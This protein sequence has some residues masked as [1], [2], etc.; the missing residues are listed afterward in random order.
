MSILP[1]SSLCEFSF[2]LK[3]AAAIL[4][5]AADSYL[6]PILEIRSVMTETEAIWFRRTAC[7]ESLLPLGRVSDQ[8]SSDRS[9]GEVR[10][11]RNWRLDPPVG[12]DA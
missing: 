6:L 2:V 4:E 5:V 1:V 8:T 9:P 10:E 7:G 12:I 11:S 3:S